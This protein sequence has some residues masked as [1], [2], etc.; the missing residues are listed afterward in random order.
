[1]TITVGDLIRRLQAFP[2]DADLTFSGVLHFYR[3]KSRGANN[4]N[5]EFNESVYRTDTGEWVIE[6]DRASPRD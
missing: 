6:G 5:V 1:M 3:L 4:V 2:A